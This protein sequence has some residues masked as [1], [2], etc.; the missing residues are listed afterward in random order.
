MGDH[1][2]RTYMWKV[3]PNWTPEEQRASHGGQY[4]TRPAYIIKLPNQHQ[5]SRIDFP[6]RALHT[7]ALMD[8]L[9]AGKIHSPPDLSVWAAQSAGPKALASAH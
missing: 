7:R 6:Y 1:S 4:N 3:Q 9:I 8:A 2:W 5:P